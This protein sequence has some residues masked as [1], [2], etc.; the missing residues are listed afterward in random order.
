MLLAREEKQ[1]VKL[2]RQMKLNEIY[3]DEFEL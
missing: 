2:E 1:I 3:Y